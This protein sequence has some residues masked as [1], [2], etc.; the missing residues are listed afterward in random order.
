MLKYI[1]KRIVIV[2]GILWMVA[3]M[4]YFT[5]HVTP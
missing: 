5:V 3:T 1:I 2:F 4:T